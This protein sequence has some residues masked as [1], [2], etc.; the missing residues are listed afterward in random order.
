M[1][2]GALG[3][4]GLPL[5]GVE[6]GVACSGIVLGVM[7]AAAARPPLWVAAAIVGVFAIFHG[8]AHGAPSCPPQPI[9]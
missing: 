3:I 1:A 4:L 2:I 6:V 5:P 8:H 7:V 9:R